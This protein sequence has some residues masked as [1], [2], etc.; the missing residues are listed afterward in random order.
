[1]RLLIQLHWIFQRFVVKLT[2]QHIVP[3]LDKILNDC[4]SERITNSCLIF[5]KYV[6]QKTQQFL[7]LELHLYIRFDHLQI[8]KSSD[9]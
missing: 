2:V 7:I 5:I 9:M 8:L 6:R 3:L 4:N 1:M